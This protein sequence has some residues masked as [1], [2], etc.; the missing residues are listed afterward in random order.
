MGTHET[1]VLG[2]AIDS[3]VGLGIYPDFPTAIKEMTRFSRTFEPIKRNHEIYNGLYNKV[4]LKMYK[5]LLPLFKEIK[6]ITGYPQQ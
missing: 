5:Q 6:N 3:V 1:S 2:A 4:Y